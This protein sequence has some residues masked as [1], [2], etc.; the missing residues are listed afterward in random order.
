MSEE[1]WGTRKVNVQNLWKGILGPHYQWYRLDLRP[2]LLDLL[3]H[4]PE[5]DHQHPALHNEPGTA[6]NH[7]LGDVFTV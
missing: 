1:S 5:G 3:L 2:P 4:R 6:T 7:R